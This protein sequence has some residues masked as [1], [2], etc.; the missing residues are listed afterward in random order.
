[1]AVREEDLVNIIAKWERSIDGVVNSYDF[2]KNE[3]NIITAKA[4]CVLHY[5]PLFKSSPHA[6]YNKWNN[7]ITIRSTLLVAPRASR[8]ANLSYLENEAMPFLQKW[9]LKFQQADVIKDMLAVS[10]SISR[11]FLVDGSYGVGGELLT[12]KNTPWIGCIFNFEFTE[13]V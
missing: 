2:A 12:I 3:T 8:G 5:P 11:A 6:H 4:P 7:S 1:M 13:I 10:P 9:R